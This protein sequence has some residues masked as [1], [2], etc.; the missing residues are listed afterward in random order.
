MQN[1]GQT[2][3]FYNADETR[4]TQTKCDLDDPHDLTWFQPWCRASMAIRIAMVCAN[5]NNLYL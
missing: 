4:L 3:I 1:L 5:G 2:Q